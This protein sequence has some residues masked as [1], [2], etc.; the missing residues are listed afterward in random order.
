MEE[1]NNMNI[2]LAVAICIALVGVLVFISIKNKTNMVQNNVNNNANTT[3]TTT[4]GEAVKTGDV[5][6][7]NYTGHLQDGTVFDSNIDPKF[8]HPG[9]PLT[10]T[11]GAGQ[12]IA[13]FDSGVVGMKVGDKK[14]LTIPPADAYGAE[15]R[16][17][18][19]PP[20]STLIFEVE[21]LKIN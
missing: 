5:V 21:L 3:T 14:T 16:P 1:K 15:G 2:I 12:M 6:S 13:G 8:G 9:Q 4:G 19:I 18:V 10:F 17:P 11:V 7:M 20:N